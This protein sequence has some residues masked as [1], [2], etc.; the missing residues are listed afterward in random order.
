MMR[1]KRAPRGPVSAQQRVLDSSTPGYSSRLHRIAQASG[2][3]AAEVGIHD[4]GDTGTERARVSPAARSW[5]A[6]PQATHRGC[7]A[8]L[9]LAGIQQVLI[10]A[11]VT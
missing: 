1:A 9:R 5:I 6:Q 3:P 11:G 4:A 10:G 7:T 2:H 8:Q